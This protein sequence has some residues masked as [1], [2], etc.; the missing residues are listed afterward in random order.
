[1]MCGVLTGNRIPDCQ[2]RLTEVTLNRPELDL[3]YTSRLTD[4][5]H[6]SEETSDVITPLMHFF[7][8]RPDWAEKARRIFALASKKWSRYNDRGYL[9]FKTS[10][11]SSTDM[12]MAPERACD[13]MYH[14]RVMQPVL[15]YWQRTDDREMGDWFLRWLDTWVDA[16]MNTARGKPAGII[17]TAI[18]WPDGTPVA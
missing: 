4:V 5:E 3:G 13:T 8:D 16:A 11:L 7:P 10:Y 18:H 12:D 2:E 17:P 9:Q 6:T 14:F 15:L 1:M